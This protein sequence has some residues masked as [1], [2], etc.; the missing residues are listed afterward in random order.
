LIDPAALWT[1]LQRNLIAGAALDV[2]EPEPPDLSQPLYGDE[3][4]VVTP[5]AAF[6]SEESLIDLR[7]RVARQ[8]ATA[9]TGGRPENIVNG[10]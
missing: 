4:V 9:L 1:A 7:A 8:I 10:L 6:V 2:F 5:H 3:R